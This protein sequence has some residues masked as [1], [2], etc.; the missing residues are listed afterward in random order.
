MCRDLKNGK[1]AP[2]LGQSLGLRGLSLPRPWPPRGAIR[3]N[4]PHTPRSKE[5]GEAPVPAEGSVRGHPCSAC[6]WAAGTSPGGGRRPGS[7][8]W[9]RGH[10]C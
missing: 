7:Q 9:S 4:P 2:D 3:V 5:E 6:I 1:E 10:G 8:P